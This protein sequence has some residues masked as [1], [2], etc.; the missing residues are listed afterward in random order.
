MMKR[1][2]LIMVV[3]VVVLLGLV[4]GYH[5]FVGM[6]IAKYMASATVPPVTVT[7][8]TVQSSSWQPQSEAIGGLRAV[9]G[10]DLATQ[11]DG[12]VSKVMLQSGESVNQGQELLELNIDSDRAQLESLQAAADLAAAVLVRSQAQYEVEAISKAQLDADAADLKSK[13]AQVAEQQ[14]LIDKKIIRAPFGGRLGICT[15]VPGQYLK[16]GDVVV[17]LQTLDP[18][19]VD[20]YV[21]QQ[22]LAALAPGQTVTMSTD[23]FAGEQFAGKVTSVNSKV[24]DSTR[25]VEVEALI[26][27]PKHELLPGM[28]AKVAVNVG[29]AQPHLTLPQTAITYNAYGATVFVAKPIPVD[30]A[31]PKSKDKD[32]DKDAPTLQAQQVFVTTGTTRGDQVEILSGLDPGALVVTTG[33]LKLKNGTPLII[34]NKIQPT[35]DANPHP[36]EH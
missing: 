26:Q 13:R 21:P 20:F 25:N 16:A 36:Q 22:Q 11:M 24:D 3:A 27:N 18:I 33:G 2:M 6:M 19:Y 5:T 32:K 17:T 29:A 8:M 4:F 7:A 1:R 30:P 15:V 28:F 10:A 31:K 14:A 12:L 9:R 34:N 23:A 35:D